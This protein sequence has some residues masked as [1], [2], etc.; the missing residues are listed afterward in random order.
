MYFLPRKNSLLK[1]SIS[2]MIVLEQEKLYLF[3][4]RQGI[5]KK[6]KSIT[7]ILVHY[8]SKLKFLKVNEWAYL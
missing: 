5:N 6:Y 2:H 7:T 8:C 4:Y 3:E 1:E